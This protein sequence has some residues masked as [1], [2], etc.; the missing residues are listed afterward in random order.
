M[1]DWLENMMNDD[2]AL[3]TYL[4]GDAFVIT[5]NDNDDGF[6]DTL[7]EVVSEINTDYGT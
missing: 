4:F 5:G 2:D 3:L 1:P 6:R 7:Y